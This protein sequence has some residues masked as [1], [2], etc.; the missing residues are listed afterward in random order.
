MVPYMDCAIDVLSKREVPCPYQILSLW[1]SFLS[2]HETSGIWS[3]ICH[4]VLSRPTS[5]NFREMGAVKGRC[6]D[7]VSSGTDSKAAASRFPLHVLIQQ[8]V[9]NVK[10]HSIHHVF[11][12]LYGMSD[13]QYAF[14]L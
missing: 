6:G 1:G 4:I 9:E 2:G 8:T 3:D 7:D 12:T 13:L 5:I 11:V 10:A 14:L